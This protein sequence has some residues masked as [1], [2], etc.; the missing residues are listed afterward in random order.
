MPRLLTPTALRRG[1]ELFVGISLLG[2]IGVLVYGNDTGAFIA[3][4]G[5]IEWLWVLA[6]LGLASM[7]WLGGGARLWVLAREVHP[8]PRFWGLVL[9]GGMGAWGSYVTPLQAGSSPMQIYTMR[10][11]GGIPVPIAATT[12]LMS[13]IATVVFFAISGPLAL[14][15]GAGEALGARGNVLGLSL[16]DLFKGSMVVFG[17]L[18]VLLLTVMIAP[19]F[20]SRIVRRAAERLGRRSARVATRLEVLQRGIDD[21]NASLITF[22]TPRGWLSLVWAVIISGPSHANKLLAGYVA[23]RTVGIHANFVDVL[24]LQTLIAFLLY[25]APTPGASGIAELL[26]AAVMS[27]Y[28]P[29]ELTPIYTLVW[30]CIL[31]WFTI[32]AGFFVFSTWVRRGLKSIEVPS[33]ESLPGPPGDG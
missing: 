20:I 16:L 9:A 4:L 13:F 26:S 30:R 32:A 7:D 29:R 1:F 8:K 10:R 11:A 33:G 12:V 25:F 17:V 6:G 18:G 31:S 15:F 5:R 2:Y 21:A 3:S 24:L 23:L 14:A 27:V 28:V 22:N 19:R